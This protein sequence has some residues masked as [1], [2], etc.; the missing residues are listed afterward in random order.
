MRMIHQVATFPNLCELS[1]FVEAVQ[2]NEWLSE[3]FQ[4]MLRGRLSVERSPEPRNEAGDRWALF[5]L[6]ETVPQELVDALDKFKGG[7]R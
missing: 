3:D 5:F 7:V 6:G 2:K 1:R 4:A